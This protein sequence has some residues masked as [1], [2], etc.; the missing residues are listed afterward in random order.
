MLDHTHLVIYSLLLTKLATF[1]SPPK[2]K[3]RVDAHIQYV[4]KNQN[5]S[6]P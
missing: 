6:L 4:V 5:V 1:N 3:P 2:M